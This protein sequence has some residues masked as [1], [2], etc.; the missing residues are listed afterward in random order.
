VIKNTRVNSLKLSYTQ[1]DVFFGNPGYFRAPA[2]RP[3]SDPICCSRPSRRLQHPANRRM[4]PAYQF[5]ESFAW[6][7]PGK[8]GDHDLKFGASSRPHST[9]HLRCQHAERHVRVLGRATPISTPPTRVPTPDPPPGRVPVAVG[10]HRHRHL[11][12]R[13]RAGQVGRINNKLTASLGLRWDTEI[14]PIEEKD[15]P[16]FSSPDDYPRDMNNFAP[17]PA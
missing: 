2:I 17:A 9:P 1:E 8:R 13:V 6:F 15:K 3:R 12:R 14:L 7:V 16:S 4:D 10:L 11:L 5:D